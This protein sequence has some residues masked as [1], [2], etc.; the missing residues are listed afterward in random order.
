MVSASPDFTINVN[1]ASQTVSQGQTVSYSVNL[2]ALNGFSSSISLSVSGLPSGA[3]GV[4]SNPSGTPNFASTLT[5]TLSSNVPTGSYTLTVT[6]SGGGVTHLANLVLTVTAS[7]VTTTSTTTSTQ[8]SDLMSLIQQ[9]QLLILG[10]IALI[11]ILGVAAMMTRRKSPQTQQPPGP[12][13]GMIYCKN[14]GTQ[15]PVANE[16]CGKCG[17]KLH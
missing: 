11:V 5:I 4:F 15:N 3:N 10:A 6:G 17:A 7:A 13:P 2:A 9:N 12:T 16:F 14:C 8:S 1:P